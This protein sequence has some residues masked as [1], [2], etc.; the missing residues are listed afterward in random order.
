MR[1]RL[2][3]VLP[4]TQ[5]AQVVMNEL[6]LA[7]IEAS[8]IHFHSKPDKHLGDLP[9]ANVLEKSDVVYCGIGG[10]LCGA[11]FGFFGG[12]LAYLV[13]WW[14]GAVS[15]AIIPYCMVIGGVAC[16][17]WAGALASGVPGHHLARYKDHIEDGKILMMVSVPLHRLSEV[18]E[19]LRNTHPEAAYSGIWPAEH[20]MFP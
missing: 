1:R 9:K 17:V 13:P 20:V 8:H 15:L 4:D 14:F 12:L 10:F 7:R 16:A 3:F 18:R 5:S 19:L 2:Y 11:A 6:L